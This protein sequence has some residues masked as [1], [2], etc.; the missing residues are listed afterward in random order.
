VVDVGSGHG[1]AA[2]STLMKRWRVFQKS[3]SV[4]ANLKFAVFEFFQNLISPD[5]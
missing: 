3:R 4:L 2:A 5:S 1:Q